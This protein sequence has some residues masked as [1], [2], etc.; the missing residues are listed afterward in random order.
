[1]FRT[2]ESIMD[3]FEYLIDIGEK[4][5]KGLLT[6]AYQWLKEDTKKNPGVDEVNQYEDKNLYMKRINPIGQVFG[7]RGNYAQAERF[8]LA[9]LSRLEELEK[10]TSKTFNKGIIYANIGVYQLAQD[11]IDQGMFNLYRGYK[12]DEPILK[13][14]QHPETDV[15]KNLIESRLYR[16]FENWEKGWLRV[17]LGI[18]NPNKL[19][20]LLETRYPEKRLFLFSIIKTLRINLESRTFTNTFSR[21]KILGSLRDLGL[22]VEDELKKKR[23][24]RRKN[25]RYPMLMD[26]L[27][28]DTRLQLALRGSRPLMSTTLLELEEKLRESWGG[29]RPVAS[30]Y[31]TLVLVRNLS[32]HNYLTEDSWLFQNA[33]EVVQKCFFAILDLRKRGAI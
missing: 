18:K 6:L 15:E 2:N 27:Q 23:K 24:R 7:R 25:G 20:D 22:W 8:Y 30:N 19:N 3:P 17:L 5:F 32:S 9:I 28:R 12:E 10:E 33:K 13:Q 26:L 4:S 16:Q 31:Q 29:G 1:M 14:L 11:K 21:G